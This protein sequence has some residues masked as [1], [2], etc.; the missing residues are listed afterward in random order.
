[1]LRELPEVSWKLE[2][3]VEGDDAVKDEFTH[4]GALVLPKLEADVVPKVETGRAAPSGAEHYADLYQS[5][6]KQEPGVE[7]T[8]VLQAGGS[9]GAAKKASKPN[10]KQGSAEK[11]GRR[12]VRQEHVGG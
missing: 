10:V 1:M 4:E 9:G 6:V 2:A 12:R 11:P 5:A 7:T 3:K 8:H